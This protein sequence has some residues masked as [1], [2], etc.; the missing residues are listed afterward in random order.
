MS[1]Y[2]P[3]PLRF[4]ACLRLSTGEQAGIQFDFLNQAISFAK[5]I[6]FG[7][8]WEVVDNRT[9]NVMASSDRTK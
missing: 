3:V 9:R 4:T 5:L 1:R 8:W 7:E 2:K 6:S